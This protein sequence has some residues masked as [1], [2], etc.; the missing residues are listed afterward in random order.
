M[1]YLQHCYSERTFEKIAN[2]NACK[3]IAIMQYEVK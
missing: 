1:D 3:I 2:E